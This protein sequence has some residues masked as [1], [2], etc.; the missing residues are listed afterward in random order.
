MYLLPETAMCSRFSGRKQTNK[1]TNKQNKNTQFYNFFVIGL[2][3]FSV[4][5]YEAMI[6]YW[7]LHTLQHTAICFG[8]N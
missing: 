5:V 2:P 6:Y 1:Q 8:N 7:K 3:D 4:I